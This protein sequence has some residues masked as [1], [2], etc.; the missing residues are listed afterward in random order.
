MSEPEAS[1]R[2][3]QVTVA[4]VMATGGCLLLVFTL[5]DS[6]A[7]VRSTEMRDSIAAFLA[8]P[9]GD[10]LGLSVD[11]A[12]D[13]VR[14]VVLLSG[15]LAAA[16]TVLSVY[17]LMRHRAARVGLSVVAVLLLLSATFVVGPLP[18]LIAVAA[19]MLWGREARDWFDGR[20]P[21]VPATASATSRPEEQADRPGLA[22]WEPPSQPEE[23]AESPEP[24]R[25]AERPFGQPAQQAHQVAA[26]PTGYPVPARTSAARPTTVTVAS[27]LTWVFSGLV[28]LGYSLV[29]LTM[30]VAKGPLLE[31]LRENQAVAELN[32]TEQQLLGFLWVMSAIVIFWAIAAMALAVLAFRR[33]NAGRIG[34]VV[35][36][37][38]AGV[39]CLAAFP[40]GWPHAIAAF[41][42]LA[43]LLRGGANEWYA[44]DGRSLPAPP[45]QAGPSDKP[46]VW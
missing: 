2:P 28:V 14:G 17:S 33:V 34:L 29:V 6:M 39:V 3:R 42:T 35:S 36:A 1:A 32:A 22:A 5:F 45:P 19:S 16:G 38:I 41:T 15:A 9:P 40:V 18:I 31:A 43:L 37:A 10:G 24:A 25:A 44:G 20:T 8:K 26:P 30:L 12:V 13:L 11:R 7:Q 21:S 27:W 23:Q 46:P 4:G